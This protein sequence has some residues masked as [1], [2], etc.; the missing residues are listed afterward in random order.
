MGKQNKCGDLLSHMYHLGA[1]E[2]EMCQNSITVYLTIM[3]N[4]RM[5]KNK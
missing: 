4:I 3:E 1:K 2:L 5:T